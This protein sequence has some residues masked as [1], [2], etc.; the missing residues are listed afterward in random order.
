MCNSTHFIPQFINLWFV[1]GWGSTAAAHLD[2]E[3]G[4]DQCQTAVLTVKAIVVGVERKVVQIEEPEET[5][6]RT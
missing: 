1:C 3:P 2:E 6:T 4:S 5:E